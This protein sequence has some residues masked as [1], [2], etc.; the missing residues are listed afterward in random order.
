MT[1]ETPR[2]KRAFI[3]SLTRVLV[4]I[5]AGGVAPAACTT[6]STAP[7]P[8]AFVDS[9]AFRGV[10][11]ETRGFLERDVDGDGLVDAVV[12]RQH[13]GAFVLEYFQ[14][15]RATDADP[16][17]RRCELALGIGDELDTLRALAIGRGAQ[18]LIV[19]RVETPDHLA[20]RVTVVDAAEPCR[21]LQHTAVETSRTSDA[22]VLPPQ[23]VL[24]VLVSEAGD[25]VLML[26]QP[27][28]VRLHDAQAAGEV[29]LALTLR[30]RNL[31]RVKSEVTDPG[32]DGSPELAIAEQTVQLLV[33]R[34]ATPEVQPAQ[35]PAGDVARGAEPGDV[36]ANSI[37]LRIGAEREFVAVEV[38]H[39]CSVPPAFERPT[40]RAEG[41]ND[42]AL[43]WLLARPASEA[44]LLLAAGE[45]ADCVAG[46]R[47][48]RWSGGER[49]E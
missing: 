9:Q 4:W 38:R 44:F 47:V 14:H 3:R 25:R 36:N 46:V 2:S 5:G 22:L 45:R 10:A 42:R 48:F 8:L 33:G 30:A 17:E 24:G 19:T 29:A 11:S 43:L 20:Q 34:R 35:D 26:D 28:V 40:L 12:V 32:G 6:R 37:R 15:T 39:A 13:A 21:V 49:D 41:T 23:L 31:V 27:K 1:A 7:P 16:F 18:V